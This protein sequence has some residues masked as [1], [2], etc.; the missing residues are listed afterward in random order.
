MNNSQKLID[1]PNA[2]PDW[3]AMHEL[4]VSETLPYLSSGVTRLRRNTPDWGDI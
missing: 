2:C 4:P 1:I 3:C